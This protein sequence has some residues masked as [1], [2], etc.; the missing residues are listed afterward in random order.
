M[1]VQRFT[2]RTNKMALEQVRE[3]LGPD[4]LILSNKRTAA[5]IEICA[6]LEGGDI[7]DSGEGFVPKASHTPVADNEIALAQLKRE[8]TDLREILQ[9]ALGERRWQDTEGKRSVVATVEQRLATLGIARPLIGDL[10]FGFASDL[11]LEDAWQSAMSRLVERFDV[12]TREEQQGLRIKAIVGSGVDRSAV[13]ERCIGDALTNFDA[14]E[15]AVISMASVP[16]GPL[17]QFCHEQGV[18]CYSAPNAQA[19]KKALIAVGKARQIFIDTPDLS[20]SLGSQDPVISALVNQRAGLT[21]LLVLPATGH[22]E[23]LDVLGR[24]AMQL[25]LAGAL[26]TQ[27]EDAT[28]VGGVIDTLVNQGIALA[29]VIERDADGLSHPSAQEM[30]NEAKRSA[31]RSLNRKAAQMKVAV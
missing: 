23:F 24:H 12:L 16:P 29:G 6:M 28:I 17:G 4:A 13:I 26:V 14:A 22:S 11:T 8:L 18:V 1:N 21:A 2:G 15:V 25:P 3:A 31:R 27:L 19:L 30:I 10:V 9:S 20:P 7:T 5:G